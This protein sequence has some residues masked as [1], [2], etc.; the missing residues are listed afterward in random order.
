VATINPQ[1]Q[2]E[3]DTPFVVGSITKTFVTALILQLAEEGALDLDAPLARWLPDYPRARRITLR[4]LLSHTSGVFNYF[5][6]PLYD[7]LVFGRPSHSWT[8]QEILDEFQREP[9]FR[10]GQGFHYSNT[11]FILLGLV[12]EQAT[13]AT[14]GEELSARFFEPL[15]LQQTYFQGDGPQAGAADGYL[16]TTNGHRRVSGESDYRPTTSAATVAWAAGGIVSTAEDIA[17]W[18]SALYGGE[19]LA[20]DSLAML[21]DYAASP[22]PR[23]TY[24]LGTRTRQISGVRAFGHTGSLRGYMAATWYLPSEDVT[25]T[26]LTNLGRIDGNRVADSLAVIVLTDGSAPASPAPSP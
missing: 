2:V 6:H 3:A 10:P 21:T 9:Y 25:V 4:Q 16:R 24:G 11:G 7:P 13:G 26:V 15:G 18:T 22:Y 23:G 20:S 19:V 12:A 14:L 8:P 1:R 5:E 17:T